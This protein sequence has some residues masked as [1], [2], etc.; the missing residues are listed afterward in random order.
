[1]EKIGLD[2]RVAAL[3]SLTL[4]SL[5]LFLWLE[6]EHMTISSLCLMDF[7]SYKILL[8]QFLFISSHSWWFIILNWKL[9]LLI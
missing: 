6:S 8:C 5:V 4:L 3:V 2:M 1:M 9:N 7:L